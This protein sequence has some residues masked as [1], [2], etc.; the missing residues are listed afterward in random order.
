MRQLFII[1]AGG[2]GREVLEWA[3]AMP[4]AGRDWEVAGFLDSR[5][6]IL[7]GVSL[8]V[9]IVGSPMDHV[10]R[11][12]HRYVCAL[13]DPRQ[14]ME[15]SRQIRQ[16][17]GQFVSVV[18]PSVIVGRNCRIGQGCIL[19]PHVILTADVTLGDLVVVNCYSIAGHDVTIGEGTTIS[20]HCSI[21]GYAQ[22]GMGVFLGTHASIL[23]K[24]VVH[25]FAVVGAGSVV[26]RRVPANTTVIGVP[27]RTVCTAKGQDT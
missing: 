16:R 12:E 6:N 13:G 27:A 18:H 11:G 17:G 24:A 9:G 20:P 26:L 14:R 25:D 7:D 2:F 22:L 3:L 21:T 23:P 19:C 10:V 5:S 15:Y 4:A 8:P 1:G